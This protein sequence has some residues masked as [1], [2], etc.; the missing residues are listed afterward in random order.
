MGNY[1]DQNGTT[2][3]GDAL[4]WLT[5]SGKAISP[6][7]LD[8]AS[9]INGLGS[10]EKL[11]DVI[12]GDE[13]LDSNDKEYLLAKLKA[14]VDHEVER[15]K[16]WELDSKSEHWLPKLIRPLVVANFTILIDVVII[17]SMWG[18]PLGEDYLPILMTM[19]VTAVG[20]YFT[21]REYGKTKK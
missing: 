3:I 12:R 18:R 4:R 17:S 11:A 5:K 9:N 6:V 15:T 20:G 19:G 16:R 13:N 14:D 10:L 7:I 1:K 8:L 2:M 21:L